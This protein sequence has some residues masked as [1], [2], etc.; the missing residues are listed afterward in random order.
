MRGNHQH[1]T[2]PRRSALPPRWG[3][4]T[5]TVQHLGTPPRPALTPGHDNYTQLLRT[6]IRRHL[7]A[8]T[9]DEGVNT[10]AKYEATKAKEAAVRRWKVAKKGGTASP[11]G[12]R[13]TGNVARL[14]RQ[15][16]EAPSTE[17]SHHRRR[18]CVPPSRG[19]FVRGGNESNTVRGE[20]LREL[21]M[22]GWHREGLV[23]RSMQLE[24][25]Y[26]HNSVEVLTPTPRPTRSSSSW[27]ATA[28][29]WGGAGVG[30]GPPAR[31][32]VRVEGGGGLKDEREQ[33]HRNTSSSAPAGV[34]LVL[35]QRAALLLLVS[36]RGR[37]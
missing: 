9:R 22:S 7:T 33:Q 12:L 14:V 30:R 19:D 6:H 34:L 3:H 16:E 31:R 17:A 8:R 11:A 5:S 13:A 29:L 26:Q 27:T 2:A 24:G 18:D 37:Y 35:T 1:L 4:I 28:G 20:G 23:E 32:G 15:W 25:E 36:N 21:T 10:P